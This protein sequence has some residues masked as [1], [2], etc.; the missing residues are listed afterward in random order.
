MQDIGWLNIAAI[1]WFLLLWVGYT[2]FA[3]YKAKR[4]ATS[5]SKIMG[6]LR[7]RWMSQLIE[8]DVLIPDAALIANLESNVTFL[9]STSILVIAALLTAL[10]STEKIHSVLIDIPFYIESTVFL[11]HLKIMVL[12]L[13]YTYAFFTFSWSMRQYGFA[14]VVIG[15]A[16][17]LKQIDDKTEEEIA[18]FVRASSKVIDLAA[19]A[20]NYGLRSYYFSLSALVWFVNVWLFFVAS[21]LVVVVLYMREFHSRPLRELRTL[22]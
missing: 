10:A 14:S 6:V 18:Q 3:H 5:I 20:Y 22:V 8:R 4:S 17:L 11:L 7:K 12:I 9:A 16:P 13:I 1:V 21:T 19:H 15:G 2:R